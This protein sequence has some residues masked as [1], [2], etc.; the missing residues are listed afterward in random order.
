MSTNKIKIIRCLW[1][2]PNHQFKEKNLNFYHKECNE[3][4]LNDDKFNLQNQIVF[5]WDEVNCDLM[6][7]LGYPYYYMGVSNNFDIELNFIHKVL[8]LKKAMEL[9]DEILFLDWDFFILRELDH[10]F[11][12][13]LR[14]SGDIQMP[15][16]FYPGELLDLFKKMDHP[17]IKISNYYNTLQTQILKHTKWGFENG[18]VIPNAGFIYCRDKEFFSNIHKIQENNNVLTNIEEICAAIYFNNTINNIDDYLQKIEPKVCHGRTD[19]EMW[20]KQKLLNDYTLQK[21]KKEIY[22]IHK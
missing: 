19:F 2:K 8:A 3:A 15:L 5:V 11:Y 12:E 9:Y 20:G 21:L 16:Y 10:K 22:F 6:K 4:K 7:K 17:D 1:G 18:F 14:S 13:L